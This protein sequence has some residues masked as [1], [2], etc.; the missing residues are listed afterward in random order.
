MINLTDRK[1]WCTKIFRYRD[2]IIVD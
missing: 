1:F 2:L